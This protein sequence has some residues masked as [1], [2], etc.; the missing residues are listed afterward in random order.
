MPSSSKSKGKGRADA[1]NFFC[2]GYGLVGTVQAVPLQLVHQKQSFADCTASSLI[3][4]QLVQAASLWSLT[5]QSLL[6]THVCESL[7]GCKTWILYFAAVLFCHK[8]WGSQG[9]ASYPCM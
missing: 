3:W 6:Y 8:P 5:V 9:I 1:G 2:T 4:E 7:L